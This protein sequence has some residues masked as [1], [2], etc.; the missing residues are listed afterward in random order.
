M[1]RSSTTF[2]LVVICLCK[3]ALSDSVYTELVL[4]GGSGWGWGV[5]SKRGVAASQLYEN[6]LFLTPFLGCKPLIA[7]RNR[8]FFS[9]RRR[10]D[11]VGLVLAAGAGEAGQLVWCI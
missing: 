7:L 2:R 4:L 3:Q 11:I 1:G 9:E 5:R 8:P 10:S 6:T